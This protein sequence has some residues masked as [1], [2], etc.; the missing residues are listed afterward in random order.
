MMKCIVGLAVV[1][2]FLGGCGKPQETQNGGVVEGKRATFHY[3]IGTGCVT[4]VYYPVGG[5]VARIVNRKRDEFGMR[6]TIES[7]DG[8][9]ANIDA[10][11]S[12]DLDFG[13]VQSDRQYQ[14]VNGLAEWGDKGKQGELRSLFSIYP[15]CV[16]LCVAADSG[17]DTFR[18]LKGKR[19]NVGNPGSGQRQNSIDAL[20][21]V[22]IDFA[23]DL[24]AGSLNAPEAP[25]MLQ[26]GRIDGFFYTVGHPSAAFKEVTSG[27][28][29]VRFIPIELPGFFYREHPYYAPGLVSAHHYPDVGSGEDIPTFCVKATLV[30]SSRVPEEHVYNLVREIF[31]NIDDF[32]ELHPALVDLSRAE[33][34]QGLSAPM[35]A[36]ARKYF[37]EAGLI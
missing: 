34:L 26:E 23:E 22:G 2:I 27:T 18:D 4:G 28:R 30:T 5:A 25:G 3:S 10:I 7:T 8:S 6:L 9:V 32:K 31:E 11:V 29:K 35:H 13:L 1:L 24:Q 15:E 14:A 17:I 12:G 33:M 19:I 37:E 36:G 16:T 20:E 21:A